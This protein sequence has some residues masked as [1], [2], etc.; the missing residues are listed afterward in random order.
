MTRSGADRQCGGAGAGG[1]G[2]GP[3]GPGALSRRPSI[4]PFR[5]TARGSSSFAKAPTRWWSY[6]PRSGAIVRRDS[7]GARAARASRSRRTAS[8]CTWR[9]PGATRSRRSTPRR[10]KW[11]AACPR[12]SNRTR[13]SR[14][15]PGGS[16]T[17]P[18]ASATTS[19][20][21]TWRRARRPS[22]WWPGAAPATWRSRRTAPASTA[23]TS[24]P[25]RASS[26]RRPNPKSR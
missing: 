9:T 25:T 21:S 24:T 26:A 6:D 14:I 23:P 17:S 19:R 3:S 15:A 1:A 13:W 16:C 2:R 20:W 18:T 5:P 22:G 8:G 4:W 11:S 12:G 10:S 7:G